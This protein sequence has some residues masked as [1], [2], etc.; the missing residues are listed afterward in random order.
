MVQKETLALGHEPAAAPSWSL[1]EV[2]DLSYRRLVVQLY[3]VVGDAGE[4]EDLVQDAFVRASASG[5][6]FLRVDN[7]EAWLR[8]TAIN[9]HRTRWRNLRNF[10]RIRPRPDRAGPSRA[11]RAPGRGRRPAPPLRGAA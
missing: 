1:R 6:R 8:R 3:A 2:F 10:T 5:A 11:R 7:P 9:P 4:A